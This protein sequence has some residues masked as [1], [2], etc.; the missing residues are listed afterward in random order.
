MD[1]ASTCSFGLRDKVMARKSAAFGSKGSQR[2]NWLGSGK[3]P[4]VAHLQDGAASAKEARPDAMAKHPGEIAG[5]I[6]AASPDARAPPHLKRTCQRDG[7]VEWNKAAP[8]APTNQGGESCTL[9]TFSKTFA[10]QG[11]VALKLLLP[12]WI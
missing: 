1:K 6:P 8:V 4:R 2:R 5:S 9:F 11:I 7:G 3:R 12:G 10:S